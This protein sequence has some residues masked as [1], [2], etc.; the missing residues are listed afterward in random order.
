V[1]F[2]PGCPWRCGYCHNPHLQPRRAPAQED[3]RQ[4][5][6]FL[7]RR[8]GLLDAVV[9]SGGEP[10]VDRALP[11][12]MREARELG[13]AVGL[14]TAGAYPARLEAVLP[15]VDWVGMDV[16]ADFAS[17]D[18]VTRAH[19]SAAAATASVGL[20]LASGVDYEL[21][22]T[23]HPS[24]IGDAQLLALADALAGMGAKRYA[25]QAFRA[26][27]CDAPEL[28]SVAAPVPAHL[29]DR[30]ATWFPEFAVRGVG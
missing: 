14:H 15:L 28:L 20:L 5:R 18:R 9:F 25:L 8:A 4:V 2:V 16:K 24:L 7:E 17:Y 11:G 26:Q 6:S 22:T 21:R 12:A 13:F 29:A 1:V 30:M 10:T 23:Y 19:G 27:G 3:W